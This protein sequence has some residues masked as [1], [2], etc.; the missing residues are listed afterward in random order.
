VSCEVLIKRP[1]LAPHS[2][3]IPVPLYPRILRQLVLK[4]QGGINSPTVTMGP[5]SSNEVRGP[6]TKLKCPSSRLAISGGEASPM[7]ITSTPP[8]VIGLSLEIVLW[9]AG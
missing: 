7:L 2:V 3:L 4:L 1:Q 8:L 6:A 9:L 5:R